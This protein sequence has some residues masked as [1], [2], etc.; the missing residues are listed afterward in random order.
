MTDQPHLLTEA[1][2]G[3]LVATLNRPDKLNALS[4]ETMALFE[5]ALDRFRDD[6]EL[7]VMLVRA[8]GRYFCAGA[9][10][11]G[12]SPRAQQRPGN[13]AP[14]ENVSRRLAS[15]NSSTGCG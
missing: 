9:D 1:R 2:E 5:A 11:R 14:E 8:E 15:K 7:R 12:G 13:P 3:V 6:P 4:G 10:M